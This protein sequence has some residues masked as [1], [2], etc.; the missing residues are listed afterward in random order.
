MKSLFSS[1]PT[2]GTWEELIAPHHKKFP[3]EFKTHMQKEQEIEYYRQKNEEQQKQIEM[4][5][6]MLNMYQ[7]EMKKQGSE[8]NSSFFEYHENEHS[9]ITL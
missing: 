7:T 1:L 4:M 9:N 8:G 5:S 3:A 2:L 6:Q